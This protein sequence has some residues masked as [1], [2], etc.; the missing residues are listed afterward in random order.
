MHSKMKNNFLLVFL[1]CFITKI[2][3]SQK[4]NPE[5]VIITYGLYFLD[6]N[7]SQM[8][9]IKNTVTKESDFVIA[10]EIDVNRKN[11]IQVTIDEVTS[12]TEENEPQTIETLAYFG[13]GLSEEQMLALQNSNYLIT[14]TFAFT[15][16]LTIQ[17]LNQINSLLL[18]IANINKT[19][20][21]DPETRE[22]FTK[23][24]WDSTR[25][26]NADEVSK[27]ITIHL[28]QFEK[29]Y[30]RAITLGLY[31]YG[32]PDIYINNLS[33]SNG[34]EASYLIN[35]IAQL[36]VEKTI[37]PTEGEYKI[38][39]EAI[40]NETIK[41]KYID[42]LKDNAKKKAKVTLEKGNWE[43]GDPENSL[44]EIVFPKNNPQIKQNEVFKDLFGKADYVT[45][46]KHDK[47]LLEV[48]E[49]A[50]L[51]LPELKE[52]FSA[53]LSV[54]SSLLMKFK[55]EDETGLSEWMWVEIIKL[56]KDTITGLLSNEPY[57]LKNIKLGEEVTKKAYEMFDY[58]LYL[59][60]GTYEG[61]ETGKIIE[62]MNKK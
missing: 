41:T 53:G 2:S 55:F 30:C 14:L 8:T 49:K 3:Y 58:I 60:D 26:N 15:P 40:T 29:E 56:E 23:E 46:L 48:S 17:S 59:P 61:N 24:Y 47:K 16:D 9:S 25:I 10:H 22:T 19:I 52:E 27:H 38:D 45:S 37:L 32:L 44:L 35:L 13:R 5:Q 43:E 33:C 54:N 7:T 39:I 21:Y 11:K 4:N 28:Y 51:K 57:Y 34:N 1:L 50:K 36:L 42:Y 62:Q 18:K 20:I 12:I 6:T 31:K